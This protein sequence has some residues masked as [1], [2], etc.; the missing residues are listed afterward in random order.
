MLCADVVVTELASLLEG[1][2]K[3]TFGA[4]GKRNFNRNETGSTT[5]D[6]LNFNPSIFEVDAHRFQNFGCNPCAFA[7]QAEQNLLGAHKV[8]PKPSSFLL[9]KHDHLDGLFGKPFE[10]R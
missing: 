5:N 7:N 4:R 9:G 8:V 6:F 3:D 1:E 2:F 10:H